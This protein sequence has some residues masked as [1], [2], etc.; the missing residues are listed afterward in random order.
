MGSQGG[1]TVAV[2]GGT[3]AVVGAIRRVSF[4]GFLANNRLSNRTGR[5]P[6]GRYRADL[7]VGRKFVARAT[8]RLG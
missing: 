6:R 8:T 2:V 3:V 7:R 1:G 5:L 4:V